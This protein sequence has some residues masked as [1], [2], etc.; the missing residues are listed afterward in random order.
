MRCPLMTVRNGAQAV[1]YLAGNREFGDRFNH[2]LPGILLLD[3]KMPVMGGFEVLE[4]LQEHEPIPGLQI[5][6]MSGSAL[7]K[8]VEKAKLLGASAYRVKPSAFADY[9]A[10][11]VELRDHWLEEGTCKARPTAEMEFFKG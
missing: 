10:L 6:V 1:D 8:D 4:W 3:I 2:P 5:I 7:P 11:A 9:V